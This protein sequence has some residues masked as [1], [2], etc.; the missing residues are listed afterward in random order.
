MLSDYFKRQEKSVLASLTTGRRGIKDAAGAVADPFDQAAWNRKLAETA[1]PVI[2]ASYVEGVALAHDQLGIALS[3]DLGDPV[4]QQ[5][6]ANKAQTFARQVNETTWQRLRA[7]LV[8]GFTAGEAL[9]D[10]MARVRA[11][12]GAIQEW[13]VEA[14][15]RTETVGAS[16]AGAI[17]AA[18]QSGVVQS[19]TWMAALD[20]R[21]RRSHVAA[22][23]QTVALDE[24]F[25]VGAY[26]G[27]A[28]HQLPAAKEVV[29]CR[30]T[31]KFT[32]APRVD[33]PVSPGKVPGAKPGRKPKPK[34]GAAPEP[35]AIV[36]PQG[37]P[38]FPADV[39][40]LNVVRGLGG[41]TGAQLVQDPATGGLF[42]RKT[43]ANEGHLKE[44]MAADAVYQTLGVNVPEFQDYR[45]A[46]GQLVKLSRYIEGKMLG[47]LDP[48][49]KAAALDE[50]RKGF[51]VDALM[52]NWDVIGMGED[53]ILV[54]PDGTVWRIDNGGALRYRAQ[55]ALKDLKA[56]NA[57][58]V[59]LWGMRDPA[60]NPKAAQVFGH[61][62]PRE[63]ATQVTQLKARF[64]AA[65]LSVERLADVV[66][67][68]SA[69]MDNMERF[70]RQVTTM[71]DDKY[72]DGYVER[73][74]RGYQQLMRDGLAEALP[75]KLVLNT[76]FT[77]GTPDP[78]WA[79]DENGDLF[80]ALRDATK[81]DGSASPLAIFQKTLADAKGNYGF[82]QEWAHQQGGHS[83]NRQPSLVK[84]WYAAQR[85]VEFDKYYHGGA[86]G[87]IRVD[88]GQGVVRPATTFDEVLLG[89]R[90]TV[91]Q[92]FAQTL[93]ALP[94][95]QRPNAADA[96][97]SFETTFAMQNAFSYA[98][99]ERTRI[100]ARRDD[101]GDP[102]TVRVV[103]TE[104][105]TV[106]QGQRIRAGDVKVLERGAMEST[107][108][109][110]AIAVR[111]DALTVQDVPIHRIMG[112]YYQGR[113]LANQPA[114]DM[115]LGIGEN[116]LVAHLEGLKMR[117]IKR[118][119]R[120]AVA[121]ATYNGMR[122]AILNAPT[123]ADIPRGL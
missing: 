36:I 35:E 76:A 38:P 49:A 46:R 65:D 56:W 96:Y 34:P 57:G 85:E 73:F 14:I 86:E 17:E 105:P 92:L 112:T 108:A 41:S 10:T 94:V 122:D 53:N 24:D 99:L 19:K 120:G 109:I 75:Q 111:G 89:A 107:S 106:L 83:W 29:N 39:D 32:L 77:R 115:F 87:E 69:R 110:T 11:E 90:Q 9:T 59:D 2:R 64:D 84:A 51:A 1:T 48:V 30:C 123:L 82:I 8:E 18:R 20:A 25:R 93:A 43:G 44:E 117:Y 81:R 62:T 68:L 27:P 54:E 22:H 97:E 67:T 5:W 63:I 98:L 121:T 47:D 102:Y 113:N 114:K 37:P 103:R 91:P 33:I 78:R 116:E 21:T 61:L 79:V 15:A 28:P 66:G 26:H 23:G 71:K 16:N 118:I 42:I 95:G 119:G 72:K 58:V 52:G 101:F 13:R 74:T 50:I 12:F 31:V 3:F 60:T 100:Q 7:S 40:A 4:A 70:A 80:D 45:N 6:L 88:F 104:N 55:G